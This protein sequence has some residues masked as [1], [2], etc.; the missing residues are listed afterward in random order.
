M[1]QGYRS[2][3]VMVMPVRLVKNPTAVQDLREAHDTREARPTPAD[4]HQLPWM[5]A[6]A[7]LS[8]PWGLR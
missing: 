8:R 7:G 2:A 3:S 1:F 6:H 5:Q 4:H